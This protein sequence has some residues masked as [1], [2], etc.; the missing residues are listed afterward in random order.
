MA[1]TK[2]LCDVGWAWDGQAITGRVKLSIFGAGGG[3]RWFGLRRC[4]H[5]SHENNTLALER[6]TDMAEVVCEISIRADRDLSAGLNL[7][8]GY[9]IDTHEEQ[10]RW[11][12]D[13]IVAHWCGR[14][15][16]R[17]EVLPRQ[18]GPPAPRGPRSRARRPPTPPAPRAWVL[19]PA[20]RQPR[21]FPLRSACRWVSRMPDTLAGGGP[22][23]CSV[24]PRQPIRQSDIM[25]QATRT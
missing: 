16:E 14:G 24:Q 25:V 20:V 19:E 7:L 12:R 23:P 9:L 10:A 4:C 21:R 5:M 2:R 11:A 13:F 22:F 1:T 17:R 18:N 3:T 8:G 15:G 6:L